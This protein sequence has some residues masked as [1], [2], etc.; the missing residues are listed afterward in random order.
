MLIE[1][2]TYF[3]PGSLGAAPLSYL[4]RVART[5]DTIRSASRKRIAVESGGC[6]KAE[7]LRGSQYHRA[8]VQR[9]MSGAA[10]FPRISRGEFMATLEP[11]AN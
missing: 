3:C 2:G 4:A 9:K 8:S 10:P 11:A 7:T 5:S 6:S 1:R